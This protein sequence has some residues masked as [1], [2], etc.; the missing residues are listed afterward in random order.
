MKKFF[1]TL[2]SVLRFKGNTVIKLISLTLG[3]VVGLLLFAFNAFELSYDDFHPDGDRMYRIGIRWSSNEQSQEVGMSYAPVAP[4]MGVEIPEVEAATRILDAGSQGYRLGE[5]DFKERTIYA[6]SAFFKVFAYR[7][8]SGVPQEE[9][10]VPWR[11]FLSE[12]FAAKLFGTDNPVGKTMMSEG[13]EW[14]VAGVFENLP[15]NTHLRFGAVKSFVSLENRGQYMG[16]GGG[17][18]FNGYVRLT[19]GT[20]PEAVEAKAPQMFEKYMGGDYEKY[21]FTLHLQPIREVYT[22]YSDDATSQLL[23][24]GLLGFV[25]LFVSALNYVLISVSA[26]ALKARMIGVHKVNGATRGDIF[27]MFLTETAVLILLSLLLTAGLL[28]LLVKPIEAMTYYVS[29]SSLFAPKNLWVVASVVGLLFLLA[30]VIPARV[31]S[32]V[33]VMQVFRQSA[34]GKKGWKR[35]L[36]GVQ[37]VAACFLITLLVVFGRQ[38]DLLM[39]K[40][41]G[42]TTENMVFSG[43]NNT[44]DVNEA[45][46]VKAEVKKLPFVQGVTF[47][48]GLPFYYLSGNAIADPETKESL[49]STRYLMTD[50]DFF[51]VM[52]IQMTEGNSMREA[53]V[54][55]GVIVNQRFIGKMKLEHPMGTEFVADEGPTVVGGVCR[56]FQIASLYSPQM[57]LMVRELKTTGYNGTLALNVRVNALTSENLATLRKC[58]AGVVPDQQIELLTYQQQL[59]ESYNFVRITRDT[60]MI[61]G[62]LAL[63]ITILGLIGFTGDEIAR[64]TKEIALRKVNG[65]TIRNVIVLL[66]QEAGWMSLVAIPVGLLLAYYAGQIWLEQFAYQASLNWWIFAVGAFVTVS[67]VLI[68]VTLRSYRAATMNPVKALKSE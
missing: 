42:Y 9:L 21:A 3:L 30:G 20:L 57:P 7:M 18:A 54:A 48:D 26:L 15:Q 64:R 58:I 6:D 10:T 49:F 23:L 46:R 39:N 13:F 8:L 27:G 33:S 68:T 59:G 65:A 24:L 16:W 56:D 36:L 4:A 1:Y 2:R 34:N 37:F 67:F 52:Q 43:I 62:I 66:W 28:C 19:K 38:Y 55:N 35:A 60:V 12:K 41:L 51:D 11:I 25:V 61:V 29:L 32:S 40:D 45:T 17:D 50:E 5:N 63:I 47:S 31:F 44:P 22:K 14:T 53:F